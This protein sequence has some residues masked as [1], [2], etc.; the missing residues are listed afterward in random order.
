MKKL[1]LLITILFISLI[2]LAQESPLRVEIELD[3]YL[4]EVY[5]MP[6]GEEGVILFYEGENTRSDNKRWYFTLYDT[7]FEE[8]WSKNLMIDERMD[9]HGYQVD[10]ENHKLYLV[11]TYLSGYLKKDKDCTVVEMDYKAGKLQQYTSRTPTTIDID[12]YRINNGIV[13]IGGQ[14]T[15]NF[16]QSCVESYCGAWWYL[17][18]GTSF[19]PKKAA[20]ATFDIENEE[21]EAHPY[22]MK[23]ESAVLS[24]DPY[25]DK[26]NVLIGHVDK[27]MPETF[28]DQYDNKGELVNTI[29]LP[30]QENDK[31]I[32][33]AE[34]TEVDDEETV[35]IGTYNRFEKRASVYSSANGFYFGMLRNEEVKYVN[36]YNFTDLKNFAKYMSSK[37]QKKV[38]K[39]K[40]KAKRKG[41]ELEVSYNL[42]VHD[43]IK[44]GDEY[45][46]IAEAFYAEYETRCYTT[47]SNGTPT[48][49]CYQ[50]F[51]GWRYTH[52]L[53]A[54]F[55]KEGD[56]LWDN[57]YK[58]YNI[59]TFDLKER[60]KVMFD[61]EDIIMVYNYGGYINSKII[62][63][64]K[65]LEGKTK[66]K[67][68]TNYDTDKVKANYGSNMDFW[69]DNYFI[70]YGTQKIKD[71]AKGK[72][73]KSSKKKRYVF[74]FNKIA[75][76]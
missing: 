46:M 10:F 37:Q 69:Y 9:Y 51:V 66:T 11:F 23:G 28:I 16:F 27:K 5:A 4:D 20:L 43:V 38:K 65:V 48:T 12:M 53:V 76:E 57:S 36:Y 71:K 74:Y 59:L 2:T 34:L 40:A 62:R 55:D 8:E 7:E 18:T 49:T 15:H 64:D 32:L 19:F 44:R 73:R 41:K 58:I 63:G 26:T 67:I 6:V 60:I 50:V 29:Y 70:A 61:D 31:Q 13:F 68:E 25:Q 22:T 35:F 39:K 14:T 56:L 1:T 17:F 75:F 33:T 24:I 72:K 45:I 21:V 47:Y 42:L 3:N 52:A 54:A 30:P